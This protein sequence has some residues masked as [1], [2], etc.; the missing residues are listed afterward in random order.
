MMANMKFNPDKG[1]GK[2]LQGVRE[3]V[4]AVQKHSRIG[5]GFKLEAQTSGQE[6]KRVRLQI[7]IKT[8]IAPEY[9]EDLNLE[10]TQDLVPP[11][12]TPEVSPKN[13]YEA[14][15]LFI[16]PPENFKS[17]TNQDQIQESCPPQHYSS[18]CQHIPSF[19]TLSVC[20]RDW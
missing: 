3:P 13:F 15:P 5:L 9:P 4:K 18:A 2:Y 10:E 11:W 7:P 12:A 19:S 20:P 6:T 17:L 1:L 14:T 16:P 8:L